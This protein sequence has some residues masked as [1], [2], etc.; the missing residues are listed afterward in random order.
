MLSFVPGTLVLADAVDPLIRNLI[1]PVGEDSLAVA[2][3]VLSASKSPTSTS[4]AI[5][6]ADLFVVNAGHVGDGDFV[7]P[8]Q[9]FLDGRR[10]EDMVLGIRD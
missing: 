9:R 6:A 7:Q 4:L 8:L 10:V 2:S 1:L 3:T 5:A